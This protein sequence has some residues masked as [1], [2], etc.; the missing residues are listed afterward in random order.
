MTHD[1]RNCIYCGDHTVE[2]QRNH[3]MNQLSDLEATIA[4]AMDWKGGMTSD[5][6]VFGCSRALA[7]D[8]LLRKQRE[9]IGE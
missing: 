6:F 7:I 4:S 1:M 5:E 2:Q 3:L 9:S 8:T